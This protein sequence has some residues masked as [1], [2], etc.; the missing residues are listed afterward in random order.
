MKPQKVKKLALSSQLLTVQILTDNAKV[1]ILCL[2]YS[3]TTAPQ[4]QPKAMRHS[5]LCKRIGRRRLL[6]ICESRVGPLEFWRL[7]KISHTKYDWDST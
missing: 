3:V 1:L 6:M 7:A 5:F 4:L 2:S